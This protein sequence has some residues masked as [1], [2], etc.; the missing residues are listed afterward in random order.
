[1]RV[2]D[3]EEARVALEDSMWPVHRVNEMLQV[4]WVEK[5]GKVVWAQ[6]LGLRF[7]LVN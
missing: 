5:K 4:H 2:L 1:M 6:V 7:A 3:L